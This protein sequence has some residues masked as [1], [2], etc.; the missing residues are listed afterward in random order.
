M[1][2]QSTKVGRLVYLGAPYS[3]EDPQVRLDRFER[4]NKAA[5]YLMREGIYVYS[6]ISHTHPIA[7][8][9]GLPT[10][11]DF[12]EGYDTAILSACGALAVL[13]LPGWENSIGLTN[14]RDIAERLSRPIFW[15]DPDQLLEV[16]LQLRA[17]GLGGGR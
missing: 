12:W 3:H 11:W 8:A 2:A 16:V 14:E 1:T 9:G 7:L 15:A 10:G 17:S 5:S 4:I 6:P 13:K